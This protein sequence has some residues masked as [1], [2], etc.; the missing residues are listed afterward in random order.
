MPTKLV[1]SAP[2][3][4]QYVDL[5]LGQPGP[6]QVLAKSIVAGISHGT[7]MTAYLGTN[8][9]I[10]KTFTPQRTFRAQTADDDP[11]FPFRWAGYE[12]VGE[13]V[14]VGEGAQNFKIGDRVWHPTPHQTEFLFEDTDPN[15]IK[16]RPDFDLD[17]AT[18]LNLTSIALGAVLDAE[19]KL[20][21]VVT[22]FGGGIVGQ[23][24]VQLAFLSGARRVLLAEPSAER[25]AFA[26]SKTA[27]ETFDPRQDG[28]GLA[29]LASGAGHGE[30][31]QWPDVAI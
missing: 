19:V 17:A 6:G 18:L 2:G 5:Q 24:A 3:A 8:P 29:L 11:F 13:V 20:G 16:L 30:T 1:I 27:V 9:F 21:D 26:E 23:M 4:V 15:A 7:E 12:L 22:V 25:G 31:N 10:E 14:A 28:A